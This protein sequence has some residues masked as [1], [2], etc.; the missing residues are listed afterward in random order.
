[1]LK[2]ADVK[3]YS[4]PR[5]ASSL[6]FGPPPADSLKTEYGDLACTIEV[7]ITLIQVIPGEVTSLFCL[8]VVKNVYGAIDHIHD[9]G[10][11]HTDVVVA[12]EDSVVQSFLEGVDSACIFANASTRYTH[13]DMTSHGRIYSIMLLYR[14]R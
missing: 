13:Q 5:L 2:E 11:G 9:F 8:Q 7:A 4:G 12:E 10:S 1:M 14:V 3:I 6:T